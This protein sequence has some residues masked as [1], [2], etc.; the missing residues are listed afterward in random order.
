MNVILTADIIEEFKAQ[1]IADEKSSATIEKYIRE[2]RRFT[3][4][5]EERTLTKALVVEYKTSLITAGYKERSVNAALAGVNSLLFF[6]QLDEYHVR[7][8]RIQ[9][10]I[11]ISEG[12]ELRKSEY[13][14][15]L[16]ASRQDRKLHAILQTIC[17]T[18]IRISELKYFTVEAVMSGEIH[19]YNKGKSRVIF[20]AGKLRKFL[21]DYAHSVNIKTGIIFRN[22]KGNAMNRSVIWAMM[23][24][25]SI[26][27]GVALSKV[28]PHN[29]RKLFARCFYKIERDIAK[30]ADVLGH[31]SINT[32][33]IYITS[34]GREHKKIIE[35]MGLVI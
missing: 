26:K 8:L 13:L 11:Y 16:D 30:L 10:Q 21:R 35:Q 3:A 17:S 25:L 12:S 15:L 34:T 1:L 31:S 32:T 28:Y 19:I 18:G 27:A 29:L 4:F 20:V 22:G 7:S 33:R 2:A 14:K 5:A 23:K 24:K 6:L 9:R